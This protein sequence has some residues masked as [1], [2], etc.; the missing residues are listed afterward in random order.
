MSTLIK[1]KSFPKSVKTVLLIQW[2]TSVGYFSVIPFLV[3][4][5]SQ[6]LNYSAEFATL[7]I[8]LFLAGQYCSTFVGGILSDRI[9]PVFTMKAGLGLQILTYISFCFIPH[10]DW[11][12][13]ILSSLIG[14]SKGLYTPAAKSLIV[15]VSEHVNRVLL[16]SVRSTVNNIGVALGSAIGGVFISVNSNFFFLAAALSQIFA[17]VLLSTGRYSSSTEVMPKNSIRVFLSSNISLI[18]RIP[19]LVLFLLYLAFSFLYIQ[20]E[21]SLPLYSASKWGG[22]SVSAIFITNAVV[23]V[24]FQ[25][26][27]NVWLSKFISSWLTLAVGFV[28]FLLF[29][30]SAGLSHQLWFFCLLMIL[31][32]IGEVIIDPTIDA[33]TSESVEQSFLGFAYGVLGVAGLVGSVLGNTVAGKFLGALNAPQIF[34][35]ICT[36][37]ASASVILSLVFVLF[38]KRM[39]LSEVELLNEK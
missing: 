18:K 28:V 1:I 8:T 14:V 37:L 6:K 4:Y 2:L 9:S 26:L 16:F 21:S 19:F 10:K 33:I 15:I 34:W 32:T 17:L 39:I 27:I 12:V 23:V 13:C 20:L 35:I 25:I 38:R 24:L 30:S 31:F 29:F 7:Q 3:V 22:S 36:A 11:V 5:V